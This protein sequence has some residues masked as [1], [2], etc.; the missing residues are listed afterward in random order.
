M[1]ESSPFSLTIQSSNEIS[2]FYRSTSYHFHRS[3]VAP[4]Q[5]FPTATELDGISVQHFRTD[6]TV[7]SNRNAWA[8]D[9]SR[10]D[11]T[12]ILIVTGSAYMYSR[13]FD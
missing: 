12:V 1:A 9:R 2:D 11:P 4:L 13:K 10:P 6:D 7:L 8:D 5:G 3:S